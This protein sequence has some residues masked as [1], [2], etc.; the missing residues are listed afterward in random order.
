MPNLFGKK[1]TRQGAEIHFQTPCRTPLSKRSLG[2][3][4][5]AAYLNQAKRSE[6]QV[7]IGILNSKCRIQNS[8]LVLAARPEK[9]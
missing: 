9:S 6:A 7:K 5:G 3:C 4:L 1:G 8:K 2:H